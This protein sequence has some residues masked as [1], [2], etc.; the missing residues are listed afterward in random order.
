M[1]LSILSGYNSFASHTTVYFS[2]SNTPRVGA[3]RGAL[4]R[5][6]QRRFGV[7]AMRIEPATICLVLQTYFHQ[8]CLPVTYDALYHSL[9]ATSDMH[10]AV[11]CT[12]FS[13]LL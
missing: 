2:S 4:Y 8:P 9:P 5:L 13:L 7:L 6:K 3:A 12:A 1:P 11:T 10:M